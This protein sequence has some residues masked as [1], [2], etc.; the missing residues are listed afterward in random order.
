MQKAVQG[1]V[2]PSRSIGNNLLRVLNSADFA[3]V[4]PLLEPFRGTTGDVLYEP[5]D[6]VGHVYFPC[7]H[8]M[9]SY[10]VVLADGR[11][12]ETALVGR[13]GAI[14]GI[15]SQGKVPAY[16]RAIVQFSGTFY[17][18]PLSSLQKAKEQSASI[19]Y[20]FSRYADCL[21]AQIFQQTACNATHSIEERTAK[22]LLS[23][24]DRTGESEI[25]LTQEQL[26]GLLG[27]GRSYV[28][29]VIQRLKADKVV[30][31]RRSRLIVG[32]RAALERLSCDCNL[33]VRRH[34][35]DVLRGVYPRD[36]D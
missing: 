15:I 30:E 8:A 2:P 33:L 12:V 29:R 31:A 1:T 19:K 18:M 9:V 7:D 35:D 3:Y 24:I 23:A 14:G 4:E 13:E 5:G 25:A 36:S 27:V 16:A 34:F 6:N 20:L 26:A 22:W 21:V 28:S 17:R 32:N 10:R 11:S